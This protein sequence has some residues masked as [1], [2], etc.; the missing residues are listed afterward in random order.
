MCSLQERYKWRYRSIASIALWNFPRDL[1]IG[2]L[3]GSSTV[4]L[5]RH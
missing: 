1:M 3:I 5:A 4:V 2:A